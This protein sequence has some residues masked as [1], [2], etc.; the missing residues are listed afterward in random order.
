M[1]NQYFGKYHGIVK[2]ID[3]PLHQGRLR[4]KV[5]D[6][7]GEELSG[8]SLPALPYVGKDAG[9][10]LVPPQ[11]TNV[12]IEFL[13]GDPEYP[14]WTGCFWPEGEVPAANGSPDIKIWK[15]KECTIKL[16]DTSGSESITLEV[17]GMKI[18]LN[19]DGIELNNGKN[20]VIKLSGAQISMNGGALEVE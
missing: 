14:V 15:T 20:A 17:K 4:A 11:E 1:S 13:H 3:D 5:T 18:V 7:F 19:N 9:L 8:W 10:F 12:W 2:E 6:V 16:D